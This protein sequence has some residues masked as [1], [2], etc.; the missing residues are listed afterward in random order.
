MVFTG[1]L[2]VFLVEALLIFSFQSIGISSQVCGGARNDK[3]KNK[4]VGGGGGG[5]GPIILTCDNN[6]GSPLSRGTINEAPSF[7]NVNVSFGSHSFSTDCP[8]AYDYKGKC[9]Q[10]AHMCT[11]PTKNFYC[12]FRI[13]NAIISSDGGIIDCESLRPYSFA[14]STI[15]GGQPIYYEGIHMRWHT[16]YSEAASKFLHQYPSLDINS[17]ALKVYDNVVP[18]R[19]RWDDCFNHLSF[20]TMPMIA[21]VKE[22]VSDSEWKQL[23][24]HASLFSAAILRLLDVPAERII[25]ERSILASSVVMP[26]V[27]GWCP[28]QISSLKGVAARISNQMTASLL[29]MPSSKKKH[30]HDADK[31]NGGSAFIQQQNE[32]KRNLAAPHASSDLVKSSSNRTIIYMPR[33]SKSTR[34]V[35]NDAEIIQFLRNNLLP[36][37]ELVI[38]GH[39]QEYKTVEALHNSWRNFAESFSKAR[40]II[41]SHGGAFNNLMWAPQDVDYV[42]FNEFPDDEVYTKSHGQTPVRCESGREFMNVTC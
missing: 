15:R 24:W 2:F 17:K 32:M 9:R 7:D 16:G 42:E 1:C 20:Q 33:M 30:F 8:C 38:A 14:H 40:V 22:F 35:V 29:N 3:G 10:A 28:P 11:T 23:N 13:E 12:L 5:G 6:R 31:K 21:H 26:W 37:Y 39:T 18:L 25:I 34:S 19:M 27:Q 4:G 36:S 41:G